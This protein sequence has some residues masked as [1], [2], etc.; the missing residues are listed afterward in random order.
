MTVADLQPGANRLNEGIRVDDMEA[1]D[2]LVKEYED[3]IAARSRTRR[4]AATPKAAE[5]RT[6]RMRRT[7]RTAVPRDAPQ[8]RTRPAAGGGA[9]GGA[10]VR[11]DR[12]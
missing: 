10:A 3:E 7:L 8:C 12:H 2:A 6:R 1:A 9:R 5:T 4:K 11:H